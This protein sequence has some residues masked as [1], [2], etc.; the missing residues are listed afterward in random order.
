MQKI[1][2]DFD[3]P[4]LPQHI[5]AVEN[6]S[7]SRFFQATLYENGKAYTAPAGASYSIMYHGFGPQ[8]QGWY[9]TIND[10]AGKRAACAVSGNV[11]TCEIARQALQV[12]GYV[13]IVLCVTTGKGYMLKSWPIECDC[14]ND[15]YDSTVEIQSF[16]YITQVSNADWNRAIQALEDLKNT[17]DPTLSLSGKAADAAKVGEAVNAEAERAK[18]VESQIKEDLVDVEDACMSFQKT[19]SVSNYKKNVTQGSSNFYGLGNAV[20]VSAESYILSVDAFLIAQ[21]NEQAIVEIMDTDFNVLASAT[22]LVTTTLQKL[23]F[24]LNVNVTDYDV[25]YVGVRTKTKGNISRYVSTIVN[26]PTGISNGIYMNDTKK[27]KK[28][29][30]VS[31]TMAMNVNFGKRILKS[32]NEHITECGV[33]LSEII[34]NT[35]VVDKSYTKHYYSCYDLKNANDKVLSKLFLYAATSFDATIAI[36]VIDQNNML[37]ITKE[38][39]VKNDTSFTIHEL[40]YIIHAGEM[41]FVDLYKTRGLSYATSIY[42]D[43]NNAKTL[44]QDGTVETINGYT[45]LIFKETNYFLPFWFEIK[46]VNAD[47]KIKNLSD[48][49]DKIKS[50]IPN[51]NS[52]ISIS[53]PNGD[54]FRVLMGENGLIFGKYYPHK[55]FFF[56]NSLLDTTIT[57]DNGNGGHNY[58]QIGLCASSNFTDYYANVVK[59]LKKYDSTLISS[60]RN[61]ATWETATTTTDRKNILDEKVSKLVNGEEDLIVIQVG[62]NVTSNLQLSTFKNDYKELIKWFRK[63]CPNATVICCGAWYTTEEKQTIMRACANDMG[64]YWCD[65]SGFANDATNKGKIGDTQTVY[66]TDGSTILATRT[67][68]VGGQASHP[69]DNGMKKISDSILNTLGI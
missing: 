59:E 10:N 14:K 62:D 7:Q 5:S 3:N 43:L 48:G 60:R 52:P 56:G 41:L 34:N 38:F 54:K 24:V 65:F 35:L 29:A 1:R 36:G 15:H 46:D 50:L 16:F 33:N 28:V 39:I 18:G 30:D 26:V 47:D 61:F 40:N 17:I 66:D 19:N 25:V 4:G 67:I 8:N 63:T 64:V 27:W 58:Y 22:N 49:V 45:G 12:P 20:D 51:P 2:V 11:V 57:T 23:S 55:V 44:I 42:A 6:D 53:N 69:N 9:D 32:E 31:Q 13:S 68:T 21:T 37:R